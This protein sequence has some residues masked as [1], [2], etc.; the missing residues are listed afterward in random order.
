MRFAS[1]ASG[2]E[3]NAL[4]VES[5]RTRIM[6]DCVLGLKDTVSRL[7][8]LSL[9]PEDL[10]AILV[11]HEHEDHA[12]GVVRLARKY[13]LPVWLT[14]GTFKAHKTAYSALEIGLIE[15][16]QRFAVGD[17]E[18]EPYPVPHDAREPVQFVFGN[19]SLRI[20]VLTDTGSSTPHIE[21]TLSGCHALVLECNHDTEMLANSSY[22]P[23]LVQRI[24]G[25][26]GHLD[27]ES[28][29]SLL[30]RIDQRRL[31]HVVAAHLSQKNNT[32]AH[33]RNALARAMNCNEE[34]IGIACQMEGFG[35]RQV[36]E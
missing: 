20:G 13:G 36:V 3:G 15:G 1:L 11:T 2:S 27:N 4:I 30:S 14:H 23:K 19:G 9:A 33:A 35:W 17:I 25:R 18:V 24:S 22:P 12:S 6:L 10:S 31:Q 7:S 5:G 32:P 8:R 29:A 26:F 28:A 16:Y 34:W 21:S